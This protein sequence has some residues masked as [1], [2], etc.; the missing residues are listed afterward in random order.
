MSPFVPP[1]RSS[2]TRSGL[3]LIVVLGAGLLASACGSSPS[4]PSTSASTSRT[5]TSGPATKIDGPTTTT[6]PT[7]Y[8]SVPLASIADSGLPSTVGAGP[9]KAQT[10]KTLMQYFENKVAQDY[11]SGNADDLGHYLA[12]SMLDGNKG[13]VNVLNKQGQRNIFKIAVTSVTMDSNNKDRV[14][15]D[16]LGN[17]TTDYF[18]NVSTGQPVANGLPGPSSLHFLVFLDFNPTNHTWY[19]T[20]EQNESNAGGTGSTGGTP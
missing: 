8:A 4:H 11:A 18:E 12:G 2:T 14:V 20:G 16:M 19:W 17:M 10:A 9:L 1:R 15:F 3:L 6:T 5:T 7:T 13:T